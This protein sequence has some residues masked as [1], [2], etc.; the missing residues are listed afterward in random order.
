[1]LK[2]L[3]QLLVAFCTSDEAISFTAAMRQKNGEWLCS[4]EIRE[5]NGESGTS[6]RNSEQSVCIHRS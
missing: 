3:K 6:E 4:R 1:L 5:Q 2:K